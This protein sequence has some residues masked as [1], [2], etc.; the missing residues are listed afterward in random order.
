MSV[1]KMNVENTG[2]KLPELTD[3]Q[4]CAHLIDRE[5]A[6]LDPAVRRDRDLVSELLAEDFLEIGSSGRVWSREQILDLLAVEDYREPAL[7]NFKCALIAEKVG[8]V[9]YRTVRM[10]AESG[11]TSA[12]LRSSLWIQESG[13]WKVRFHQGT[14]IP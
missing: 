14:K 8:L 4:L 5:R 2:Q 9:T 12:V 10:D 6:L 13:I 7:E 11:Q 1:R 3:E